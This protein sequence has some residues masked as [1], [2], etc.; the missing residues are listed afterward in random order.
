MENKLSYQLTPAVIVEQGILFRIPLY[1]RLFAWSDGE[2]SQLLDDLLEHFSKHRTNEKKMYY[3]GMLT[4]VRHADDNDGRI[5][6]IDGQQRIT[7]TMLIAIAFCHKA[8]K[9]KPLWADFVSEAKRVTF[10]GRSNDQI[11]ISQLLNPNSDESGYVNQKMRDGLECIEKWLDEKISDIDDFAMFVYHRMA[12]FMTELPDHYVKNP[13]SLNEYFEVM[14]S[15]GKSLQQHEILK[16]KLIANLNDEHR[17]LYTRLW[18]FI[19][20]FSHP[21]ISDEEHPIEKYK[22]LILECKNG[23]VETVINRYA[24]SQ[25]ISPG[26]SIAEVKPERYNPGTKDYSDR[27][28]AIISFSQFLLMTLA[29]HKQTNRLASI[30]SSKLLSTFSENALD[31]I[32]GF[33]RLLLLNRLLMDLYVVR[34]KYTSSASTHTLLIR[35]N[36]ENHPHINEQLRQFQAMLD[37]STQHH[38]WLM[39]FLKHLQNDVSYKLIDLLDFLKR[40]DGEHHKHGN[41]PT[42]EELDYW[43]KPQYWFWRLDYALWE[44]LVTEG[45]D[46]FKEKPNREVVAQ[47]EFR[48][49]RSIEHLHPQNQ[50]NNESWNRDDIDRFGNLA[51]ISAG[52]NSSQSNLP[53]HVKFANLEVQI[54]NKSLQSIKLYFM[55]LKAKQ[56]PDEWTKKPAMEEHERE[57]LGILYGNLTPPKNIN[58][59]GSSDSLVTD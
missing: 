36:D 50:A 45:V 40:K 16:V 19:A 14:N 48:Q 47:Y 44:R 57:M 31:D 26:K 12:L 10:H 35:E 46:A 37:V 7:V 9:A 2:V 24:N 30:H 6:M 25:E 18:N 3:V 1:Q 33:Y 17:Q 5:D 4:G 21:V 42:L 22:E 34:L 39:P 55:Y 28:D 8:N 38:V 43:H 49:N 54:T 59:T 51:M 20:D 32:H 53:V 11:F 29:M 56:N 15:S 52:F 58:H 23:N 13:S 27:E 41:P